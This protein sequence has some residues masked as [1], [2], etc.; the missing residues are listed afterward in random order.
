MCQKNPVTKLPHFA[1]Q[2]AGYYKCP[3]IMRQNIQISL[4]SWLDIANM[5][6]NP[7]TKRRHF[8]KQPAGHHKWV[9]NFVTNHPNVAS[10]KGGYNVTEHFEEGGRYVDVTCDKPSTLKPGWIKNIWMDRICG[11]MSQ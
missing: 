11:R 6:K 2:A 1:E 10:G 9:Q 7:V 5:W 3:K 4:E 8:A